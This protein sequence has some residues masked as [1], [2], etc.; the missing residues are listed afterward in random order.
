MPTHS[1][2]GLIKWLGRDE[3]REPFDDVLCR[4]YS[5]ACEEA[6]VDIEEV[7]S[8]LGRSFMTTVW[9]CAFERIF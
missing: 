3:W 7:A 4:H 8:I 1:L 5:P 2:D 6:G 9:G